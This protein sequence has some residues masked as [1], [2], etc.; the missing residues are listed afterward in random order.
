MF[1]YAAEEVLGRPLTVL[2]PDRFHA[3]HSAAVDRVLSSG[4]SGR[5]GLPI[6]LTGRRKGGSEFPLELSLADSSADTDPPFTAILR[7]T[8][9]RRAA[10]AEREA[11]IAELQRAL[12]E[13]RTLTGIIPICAGCKK[14]RDDAGYWQ[15]VELYVGEHTGADFSHSL[16]PDCMTRLYPEFTEDPP[17]HL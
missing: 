1:G 7:D 16:C 17:E 13:V 11:L 14:V 15:A 6:E 3:G 10:E 2:M 12:S 5:T 4:V 8:T 9:A